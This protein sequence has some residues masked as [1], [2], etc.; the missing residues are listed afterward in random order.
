MAYRR[1]HCP[2]DQQPLHLLTGTGM[3]RDRQQLRG[4]IPRP[5]RRERTP[6]A[7]GILG[8]RRRLAAARFEGTRF[9]TAAGRGRLVLKSSLGRLVWG[10]QATTD[11]SLG[12]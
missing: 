2:I 7:G 11:A 1:T 3:C 8:D 9:E 5:R 6:P 12:E 10:C 4:V